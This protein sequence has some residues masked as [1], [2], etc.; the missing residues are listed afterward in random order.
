MLFGIREDGECLQLVKSQKLKINVW[1]NV[2]VSCHVP[3]TVRSDRIQ[4]KGR[5]ASTEI[6]VHGNCS[7]SNFAQKA[8]IQLLC[9]HTS[10]RLWFGASPPQ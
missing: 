3:G 5:R 2:S 8:S 7:A 6:S 1:E 10:E 4:R 9:K